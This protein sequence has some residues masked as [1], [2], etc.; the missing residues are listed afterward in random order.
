MN[1]EIAEQFGCSLEDPILEFDGPT[2]YLSNF[3]ECTLVYKSL[4]YNSSEHA[5][6]AEKTL[7]ED[8]KEWIRSQPS[9]GKAKRE[10]KKV[11]L[12]ADWEDVKIQ[13][14]Y[15][16]VFEKF[17]QNNRLKALLL[18]TGNRYL[19]EG[20]TWHDCFWGVCHCPKCNHTGKNSL[21]Q[22]L[23]LVRSQLREM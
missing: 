6:M 2:R 12:R 3:W 5:F 17:S 7:D 19:E 15:A 4:S 16:I 14:M 22:I 13:I 18:S 1:L 9:P 20:N 11:P 8:L 23:M 10:G 21:G